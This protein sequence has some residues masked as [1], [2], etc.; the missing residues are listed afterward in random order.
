MQQ[1]CPESSGV[2]GVRE[3]G[4]THLGERPR[5]SLVDPLCLKRHVSVPGS[6]ALYSAPHST[7]PSSIR[8]SRVLGARFQGRRRLEWR[9]EEEG[10]VSGGLPEKNHD[11]ALFSPSFP[12]QPPPPPTSGSLVGSWGF[13]NTLHSS[14]QIRT[15]RS[16]RFPWYNSEDTS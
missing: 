11:C 8:S 10:C 1:P 12:S 4:K 2:M 15:A 14:A 6:L 13:A 16:R 5:R 9:E 7:E 3:N